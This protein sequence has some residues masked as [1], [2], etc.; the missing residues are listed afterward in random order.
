MA[1]RNRTRNHNYNY[2]QGEEGQDFNVRDMYV[3]D[4]STIRKREMA[5]LPKERPEESKPKKRKPRSYTH[6]K[7]AEYAERSL[8]FDGA[9]LKVLALA[10]IIMIGCC[11][12]MV[13][14]ES[15]VTEQQ[16]NIEDMQ[17]RIQRLQADNAAQE[18]KLRDK[19]SLTYVYDVA[20]TRLGM[21]YSQKGQ[22]LYYESA[23]EDYVKQMKDVPEAR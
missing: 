1:D 5:P 16:M 23:K 11:V 6:K 7:A 17:D 21:V 14:V 3:L 19:Y 20:T 22:V 8:Y 18:E 12:M 9:Y 4:G 15:R 2:I 13:R 10:F